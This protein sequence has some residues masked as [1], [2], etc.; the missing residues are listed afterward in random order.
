MSISVGALF[1]KK[2][3]GFLFVK[4]FL[5][6]AKYAIIR[7]QRGNYNKAMSAIEYKNKLIFLELI[8]A[9]V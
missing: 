2:C 6:G 3:I 5:L 7:S 1:E 4:Y 9:S 8:G